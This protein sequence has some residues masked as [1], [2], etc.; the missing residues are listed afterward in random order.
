MHVHGGVAP[1]VVTWSSQTW[2]TRSDCKPL[3]TVNDIVLTFYAEIFENTPMV[4]PAGQ[5]ARGR[6]GGGPRYN[7]AGT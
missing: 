2:A 4:G 7:K 1:E 3:Y 5:A 6:R